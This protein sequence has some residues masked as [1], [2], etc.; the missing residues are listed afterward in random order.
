MVVT[1]RERRGLG[2]EGGC[3]VVVEDGEGGW[4]FVE[5]EGIARA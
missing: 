1:R 3:V 5:W 4:E 2:E